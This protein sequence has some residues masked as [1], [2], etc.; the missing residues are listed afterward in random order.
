MR[1]STPRDKP[2]R[3][4]PPPD[5][6]AAA[7][8]ADS[9][10]AAAAASAGAATATAAAASAPFRQ[11]PP[12]RLIDSVHFDAL[13]EASLS[14]FEANIN[15]DAPAPTP[16]PAAQAAAAA[17]D[18]IAE[19][20]PPAEAKAAPEPSPPHT[21]ATLR[22]AAM[23]ALLVMA[24]GDEGRARLVALPS[25]APHGGVAK[26][27]LLLLPQLRAGGPNA[28]QFLSGFHR[29]TWIRAGAPWAHHITPWSC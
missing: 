2:W 20:A 5:L 13:L 3:F 7:A 15:E 6:P 4:S 26:V 28:A 29:L 21:C 23:N 27:A 24:E 1:L 12:R 14:T 16:A 18:A 22:C 25:A 8:A 9:A 10:G 11:P 19:A 17:A